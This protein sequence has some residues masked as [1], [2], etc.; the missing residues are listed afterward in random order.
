VLRH[1]GVELTAG[2]STGN[3]NLQF[4][5]A[6]LGGTAAQNFM[7]QQADQFTA[8][9][10]RRVGVNAPRATHDVIDATDTA[11]GQQFDDISAR[12]FIQPDTALARDLQGAWR[13]FEGSTN[14]ST[15]P[16]VIERIIQ[17]IYGRAQGQR[18]PGEWYKSTRSELGRLGKSQNPELSEAARDVQHALDDVM[19]RTIRQFN[20]AD[21][22]AWQE[23][24]RLYR[25]MLVIT[26]AATRAG[27][28]SAEGIITPQALRSAAIRHNKRAFSRGRSDFTELADA[29][30]SAMTPLQDSGTQSWINAR[31]VLPIGA[32]TGAGLGG[33]VG[34]IPGAV[35]GGVVGAAAPWA[36]GR[37]ILSRPGRAYL[38][39]QVAA[40]AGRAFLP[41]AL[42]PLGVASNERDNYAQ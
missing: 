21:H 29:G 3:R 36:L 1:E 2:Q 41:P 18:I 34:G 22:G 25:N 26:D 7:E 37:A 14:P 6:G 42:L 11:I 32:G 30:V 8:A 40:G 9:A 31:S 38:G 20:P 19:E 5:E 24:R 17:D 15:R 35:V 16:R 12:N 4:R 23:V 10:L 28:A 39:N 13:R 33:V 27:A